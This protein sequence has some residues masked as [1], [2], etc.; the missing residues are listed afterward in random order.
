MNRA[1]FLLAALVLAATVLAAWAA[2]QVAEKPVVVDPM[3]LRTPVPDPEKELT[4]KYDGKIVVFSGTLHSTGQDASTKQRWYKLAIPA[5][6][7]QSGPAAKPKMQT[8]I[9][10]VYFA[11]KE[12]SLPTRPAAYYTVEGAG[13]I[14]VDGALQIRNARTVSVSDKK[15][16][17]SR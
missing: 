9:V 11:G 2:D 15:P 8:V 17:P 5:I 10:K 13:E 1:T 12:R 16:A 3:D 7:E 14:M 4:L 6:L